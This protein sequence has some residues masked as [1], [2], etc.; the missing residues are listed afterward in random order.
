MNVAGTTQ[1]VMTTPGGE[2]QMLKQESTKAGF[3]PPTLEPEGMEEAENG[4][5]ADMDQPLLTP[6]PPTLH[7][8]EDVRQAVLH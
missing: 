5:S 4:A 1:L 8:H 6:A 7:D 3:D 2:Q